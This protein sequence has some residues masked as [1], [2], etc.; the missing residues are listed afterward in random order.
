MTV[1]CETIDETHEIFDKLKAGGKVNL[2]LQEVFF[3]VIG[4]RCG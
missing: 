2:D 1:N 3:R 4:L